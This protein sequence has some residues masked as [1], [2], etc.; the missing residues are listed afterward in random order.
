[1][2]ITIDSVVATRLTAT[3]PALI[4]TGRAAVIGMAFNGTG[5]GGIQL[6]AATT[7][8]ASLTPMITFSATASAVYGGFSPMFM[9]Y[10]MMVSGSG[11]VASSLDSL[12][13]N[14]VL[15]WVPIPSP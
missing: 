15:F 4:T 5:T 6:F 2:D 12:D 9:R 13:T 11:L 1:M 8:S 10:P 3:G 14:V 7:A